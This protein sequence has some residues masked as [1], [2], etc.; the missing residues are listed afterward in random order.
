MAI[1]KMKRL[2]VIMPSSIQK[3]VVKDLTRLGCVEIETPAYSEDVSGIVKPIA[4]G[5]DTV[6][7]RTE[8]ISALDALNKYAPEKKSFLTPRRQVTETALFDTQTIMKATEV[9]EQISGIIKQ[10]NEAKTLIGRISTQKATL[11]PWKKSDIPF[12]YTGGK[13]FSVVI[14][15]CPNEVDLKTI[16]AVFD[17]QNI[18]ATVDEINADRE[19]KYVIVV[20]FKDA[21]EEALVVL[22]AEGFSQVLFKDLTGTAA[23]NLARLDEEL[24]TA[25]SKVSQ[26]EGE[27]ADLAQYREI[28][29]QTADALAIEALRESAMSSMLSTEKTIYFEGWVP[30]DVEKHVAQTLED[31]GC[32]YEF[33]DP[34]ENEEPPIATKNSKFVEPF[35]AI[36]ELYG[37]P[38]YRSIIDT[39]P[40][41]AI[42]FVIFF[43]MMLSDAGC[44]LILTILTA[45][46]LKKKKPTGTMKRF[47]T[48]M[49]YGGISSF[50]WGALFGSWFG[51]A[52]TAIAALMGKEFV[53][54]PLWFDPLAEPML[55]LAVSCG[56]G[57][58][59]LMAGM[60][61][62]AWRNIKQGN[63]KDA[64]F[65]TGFWYMILIG[66]IGI[67]TGL[68]I[69]M[70]I[71]ILGAAGVL[72]T[73]GRSKKNIIS[74]LI[75]GLG[76][77]YGVT[78]YLSDILSY[79]RLM[80]LGLCTGVIAMVMNLMGNLSGNTGF[81]AT[82]VFIIV[83]VIGQTFN[84]AISLLG[85]FIHSMRLEFVEFFGKFY[86]PGGR[87]FKPLFNETKYIQVIKEEN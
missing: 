81:G 32:A 84:L 25:E 47:V 31:N 63:I 48:V 1:V 22:K 17:E 9:T 18:I 21:A 2:R 26:L 13:Y 69:F 80:A 53:L 11:E 6:R 33:C 16:S 87:K 29:E 45:I 5:L 4:L 39:N 85:A 49:F 67:A 70:Y 3:K 46:I 34:Q 19:Q 36:T 38:T 10:I 28:L 27:F 55:I 57:V 76:A 43:G 60:G 52:P 8:M 65:D 73:A 41:L 51:N 50:I 20:S 66:G 83:F 42:S 14:G 72:L 56:I 23:E 58:I 61:L 64:I 30:F 79:A 35:G 12:E 74:R 40:T 15:V 37:L 68:K 54:K 44:G 24:K 82:I 77:L 78:G 62:S 7:S 71:A 59:H 86:E 75:S